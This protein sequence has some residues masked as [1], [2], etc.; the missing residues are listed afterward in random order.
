METPILT[1]VTRRNVLRGAA[2]GSVAVPVLAACGGGDSTSDAKS[3]GT[4]VAAGTVL[5]QTSDIQVGDAVFLDQPSVVVTQP[6]AGEFHAFD[7]TCTHQQCPVTDIRDGM[8]HCSCH[9]SLY[10]MSTGKNVGGPAPAPLTAVDV[11]V[12]GDNVVVA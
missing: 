4:G 1:D 2:L 12:D 7:R 11:K 8:I 10:D 5:A 3:D 9:N 6:K